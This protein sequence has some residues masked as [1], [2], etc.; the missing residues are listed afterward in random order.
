MGVGARAG[1]SAAEVL[2]LV[3]GV[4]RAAGLPAGAVAELATLD[5]RAAEPGLR[6]AAARLGVPLVAYR[7]ME[8]AAVPVPHPS[9]RARAAVGTPSVAE[10]AALARGGRLLVPKR[11]SPCRPPR[12]TCAIACLPDPA[13]LPAPASA[14]PATCPAPAEAPPDAAD[15]YPGAAGTQAR[16][17]TPAHPTAH[18]RTRGRAGRPAT[19]PQEDP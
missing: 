7:A 9:A 1:V 15:T 14:P 17:G 12:A 19:T 8:L 11:P 4:L 3:L 2:G 5:T 18:P 6:R 13:T 16:P 10:A